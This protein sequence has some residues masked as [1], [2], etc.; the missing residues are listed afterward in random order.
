MK[1]Q[2]EIVY[3]LKNLVI[4]SLVKVKFKLSKPTSTSQI[5]CNLNYI[6]IIENVIEKTSIGSWLYYIKSH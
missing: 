6:G 2:D 1:R 3:L 5:N 4:Y